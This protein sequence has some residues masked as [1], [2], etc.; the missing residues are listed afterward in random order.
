VYTGTCDVSQ[1][2]Y[3]ATNAVSTT[4]LSTTF[5]YVP[6]TVVNFTVGVGECLKI[7]FSTSIVSPPKQP[8]IFRALFDTSASVVVV[9]GQIRLNPASQ[10][11]HFTASFILPLEDG[12]GPGGHNVKIQWQSPQ[13]GAVVASGTSVIVH[14]N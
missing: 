8:L 14:H 10:D 4:V 7:E 2:S 11:S 12:L 5:T 6:N 1:I 9:P 3:T 13:S